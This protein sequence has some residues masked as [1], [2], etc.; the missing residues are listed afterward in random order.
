M[1]ARLATTYRSN[2]R[3]AGAVVMPPR[4]VG[5][6]VDRLGHKYRIAGS[7]RWTVVKPS[8]NGARE[9]ARRRLQMDRNVGILTGLVVL[10][11]D[12]DRHVTRTE[13]PRPLAVEPETSDV[14]DVEIGLGAEII[15]PQPDR[16]GTRR[17]Q[18]LIAQAERASA[19]GDRGRDISDEP[20]ASLVARYTARSR[21]PLTQEQKDR[22]NEQER[23]RRA[24]AKAREN[25]A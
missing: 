19:E 15:S 16:S 7:P 5:E 10:D 20:E 17:A 21:K 23:A 3:Q 11:I 9:C 22:K 4:I 13:E 6:N 14:A 8:I 1:P 2:R 25:V 12:G 18:A 24:A